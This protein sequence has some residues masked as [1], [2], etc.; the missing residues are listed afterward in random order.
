M[1]RLMLAFILAAG[2]GA[3]APTPLLAAS[4]RLSLQCGIPN[5]QDIVSC[6]LSGRG[7]HPVERLHISYLVTFTA[8]PRRH[9]QF[10]QASY[11]RVATSDRSGDFT[12][13]PLG[14]AVV[15]YHESFRLTVTVAG[16]SGDRATTTTT[17]IAQ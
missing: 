16:S 9:G 6:R 4:P 12:R 15:R 1:K 17:A 7:F 5:Q 3:V 11:R 8:L 2:T 10:P 13:P 14:F